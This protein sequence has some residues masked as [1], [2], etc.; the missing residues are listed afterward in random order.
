MI[1]SCRYLLF[2]HQHDDEDGV[3]TLEAVASVRLPDWVHLQAD[4]V[5]VLHFLETHF[6]APA[7]PLDDGGVWDAW[8]QV[9]V[10]DAPSESLTASPH[11]LMQWHPPA[12]SVWIAITLTLTGG[13]TGWNDVAA[14]LPH[15]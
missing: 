6:Q 1:F 5:A 8:L 10:D 4:V 2:E 15:V 11:A 13:T 3:V 9:Q 14:I 7:T 12:E